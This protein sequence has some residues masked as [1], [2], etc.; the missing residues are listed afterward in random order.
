VNFPT[1]RWRK[2]L[3]VVVTACLLAPSAG[4]VPAVA[5]PDDP[6]AQL[7]A[8][9]KRLDDLRRGIQTIDGQRDATT[10]EIRRV[11]AR[12][13]EL[14]AELDRLNGE[15]RE[16]E[17]A[18][19]AAVSRLQA[20]TTELAATTEE[21]EQ[22]R[23][24]LEQD[25]AR[26]AERA[27]QSY[28]LGQVSFAAGMLDVETIA[29]FGRSVKYVRAVMASDRA[30]VEQIAALERT[31]D[32]KAQELAALKQRQ[33][34]ERLAAQHE[35]DR[36]AALVAEQEALT[37]RVAQEADRLRVALADLDAKRAE[38]VDHVESLEQES[39]RIE[40]ELR[41]RA[42]EERRRAAEAARRAAEEQRRQEQA[43]QARRQQE[44]AARSQPSAP[45]SGSPAVAAAP[46][47]APAAPAPAAAPPARSSSGFIRPVPGPQTSGFGPRWGRM[48]Q[49]IDIGAPTG[50]P[51]VAAASGVV[52]MAGWM[53]GYGN[54]VIIDHG[55]GIATLYAHQSRIAVSVGQS[56][57]QGQVIGYVGSTGNS[58][59]PHLH[60][61]VRVN[62]VPRNP[63]SY[64]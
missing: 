29:E 44:A 31:V 37:E 24:Q 19:G 28:M 59:G 26:F 34:Q 43:A 53:G 36:V 14:S 32:A 49:G 56:V 18:L 57:G 1:S 38:Y 63:N 21:L 13:R 64:L 2:L 35:R 3:L 58:T 61:E 12:H 9:R 40:A 30:Q 16:A 52:V 42:E 22:T 7:D 50:T 17:G 41:R 6:R 10:A 11:E 62:G 4:A 45:S 51:I 60:F 5:Q 33:E 46:A 47:P 27:R 55:G 25:R 23:E 8:V 48:H 54:A 39:A 15:L 20:T